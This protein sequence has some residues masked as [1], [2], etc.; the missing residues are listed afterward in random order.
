MFP[1]REWRD[2]DIPVAARRAPVVVWTL[3][4]ANILAFLT[5]QGMVL[6]GDARFVLEWGFVPRSLSVDPA[7]GVTTIFTAMFLHGGWLHLL[8]NMWFLWF[9]G[10]SV[11]DALGH[12]RFSILYVLGGVVA[13]IAQMIYAP[14]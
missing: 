5:E 3:V 12:V 7:H 4:L 2:P 8:G 13:A 9:F 6:G 1:V 11:E 10:R 14:A